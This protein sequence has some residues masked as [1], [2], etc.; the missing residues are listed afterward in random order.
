MT[1]LQPKV[2]P[3][4]VMGLAVTPHHKAFGSCIYKEEC[5]SLQNEIRLSCDIRI[6]SL[7]RTKR[8]IH[9]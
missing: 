4:R 9:S 6:A 8:R 7:G 1:L 2:L 5:S 3:F